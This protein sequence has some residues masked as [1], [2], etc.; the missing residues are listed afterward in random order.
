M[1]TKKKRLKDNIKKLSSKQNHIYQQVREILCEDGCFYRTAVDDF[2]Y[3][4]KKEN[5]LIFFPSEL[6]DLFL[7]SEFQF[8]R[9]HRFFNG[10]IKYLETYCYKHGENIT[11]NK[12]SFFD[13]KN[14]RL[15]INKFDGHMLCL[16]GEKIKQYPN[17]Y[18]GVF[19]NDPHFYEPYEVSD[20]PNYLKQN[21]LYHR[22]NFESKN[23]NALEPKDQ[24]F[25]LKHWIYITF[26]RELFPT[27]SILV[28]YGPPNSRKT[29][30]FRSIMLSL[31]GR[32]GDVVNPPNTTRDL[33]VVANQAH[34][35]FIDDFSVANRS[36]EKTLV[37]MA[38][39][40]KIRER[41]MRSNRSVVTLLPDAFIGITTKDPNLKREDFLQRSLLLR[42][43][44]R[45]DNRTP[46]EIKKQIL[47]KRNL[48]WDSLI[49]KL[50]VI[51]RRFKKRQGKNYGPFNFRNAD[52]ADFLIRSNSKNKHAY[53][54][55]LLTKI[56]RDQIVFLEESNPLML[57]LRIWLGD[58]HNHSKWLESGEIRN[59]LRVIAGKNDI[60]F[61]PY[62]VNQ[63]FGKEL[64]NVASIL[65][66]EYVVRATRT[67][68][69][70]RYRFDPIK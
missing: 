3:H 8:D 68:C 58:K 56:Q 14:M 4:S 40:I 13:T 57:L 21:P 5:K 32:A 49:R 39:G 42:L 27:K 17:G 6:F 31:F 36:L 60:G 59:E 26:F 19:F 11:F 23:G 52:F 25:I 20:N 65:S 48:I 55:E 44:P 43:E 41:K 29:A 34:L 46:G 9:T 33:I 61:K 16:D 51:V 24:L 45:T 35:L 70:N 53:I 54:R 2:Y 22:R 10:T 15:Y 30:L 37:R 64:K 62:E 66:P 69:R 63:Y 67:R 7:S 18:N 12:V 47:D 50:N 38:T 28:A 1:K